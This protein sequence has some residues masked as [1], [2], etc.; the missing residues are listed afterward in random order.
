MSDRA[1][2]DFLVIG[3]DAAGF[4]AAAV[5]AK[6]GAR[7]AIASTGHEAIVPGLAIEPPDFVWRMLDLHLY[8]LKLEA[9]AAHISLFDGDALATDADT[10]KTSQLLAARE[11]SLEHLW[12]AFIAEAGGGADTFLSAHELL[13]DHFADEALK[14]HLVSSFVAPF[15]LAGDEAGS[16]AA[17]A[18][19][20]SCARRRVPAAT[21]HDALK[22]AATKAGVEALGGRVTG[23]SRGDA[24]SLRVM[25][26]NGREIRARRLMASTAPGAEAAGLLVDAGASPL[27]RRAGAEA[28]IVI[29]YDKRPAAEE[30][31][32]AGVFHTAQSAAEIGL[33]RDAMIDGRIE[34]APVLSF[35]VNG[36]EIIARAAFAPA[37]LRENGELR[38]WTGQDR[39][40]LGRNAAAV[41]AKRLD[42][43]VGSVREI[44]V[45]IGADVAAG[46]RR[47]AFGLRAVRAPEPSDDEIG[48]AARLA[49][50]LVARD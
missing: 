23:L 29:R 8:G 1:S 18:F 2:I 21:L 35:T 37:Q 31:R 32:Q 6:S 7:V 10:A 16:A 20:A 40:I 49:L 27:L 22:E 47:R 46:L 36:K 28:L 45:T 30:V 38:E 34:D 13:D 3:A 11:P 48:A 44:E 4:A 43:R 19:A 26:D 17:L 25:L 42:G 14:T 12:P 5:A 24:K 9:P 41:I 39:Q 33:A 15:G 50:E